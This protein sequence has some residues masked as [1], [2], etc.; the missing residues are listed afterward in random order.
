MSTAIKYYYFIPQKYCIIP[1]YHR[2]GISK[3]LALLT[4]L[5]L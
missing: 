3:E 2:H 5:V 1:E 4:K